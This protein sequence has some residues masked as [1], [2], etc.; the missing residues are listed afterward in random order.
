MKLNLSNQITAI[1]L[2]LFITLLW[3]TS[4]VIIK[5]GLKETPPNLRATKLLNEPVDLKDNLKDGLHF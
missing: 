3:S 5:F 1:L 2:A 4:L